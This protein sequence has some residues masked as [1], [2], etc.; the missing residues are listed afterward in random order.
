ML[1]R[2]NK[3]LK[4]TLLFLIG[5]FAYGGI[6]IMFRGYSHISMLAAG[7]ICFILIGLI[8]EI[9]S[10]DIAFLS[11]MVISSVIITVVEFIFGLVVNIWMGLNVWDYSNQP[12][13]IMGQTCILFSIIWF[14]L[15]PL[16]ILLD[17]YLRYYLL[18]E[19]KPRYKL[20]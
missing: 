8:N 14:F 18:G 6:E 12:Y 16:A 7:G 19:E 10:W 13:N 20:F 5:G 3:T 11:Q 17:D 9:F 4:Y 15:S 1:L 2:Y